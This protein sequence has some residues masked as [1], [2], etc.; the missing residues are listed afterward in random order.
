MLLET[1]QSSLEAAQASA[2]VSRLIFAKTVV[3]LGCTIKKQLS[4]SRAAVGG[5]LQ[6]CVMQASS[7]YIGPLAKDSFK[8]QSNPSAGSG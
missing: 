5:P 1:P 8:N 6:W 2:G 7:N 4:N 3:N